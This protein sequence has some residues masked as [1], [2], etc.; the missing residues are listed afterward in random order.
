MLA[1]MLGGP[2]A[3]VGVQGASA[4]SAGGFPARTFYVAPWGSDLNPGTNPDHPWRSVYH[5]N[6]ARLKPGDRVLFRGGVTFNDAA[7]MPGAAGTWVTGTAGAPVTFASYGGGIAR[8]TKGIYF[9]ASSRLPDGPSYLTFKNL[10]LGAA[11]GFEGT[12]DWITLTGLRI[13]NLYAPG[14]E[15][16]ILTQ[17]SHWRITGNTINGTGD[18][19]MLLGFRSGAPGAPS[20]GDDY[21]VAHNVV[22]RTGL[23]HKLTFGTHGIYVKVSDATVVQNRITRFHD[24]GVSVRYRNANVAGNDISRGGIGVAWFQYDTIPGTSRFV[25]NTISHTSSA[26]VFVCGTRE[27]CMRPIESFVI[28]GNKILDAQG[29]TLNLQ[30]TRGTYRVSRNFRRR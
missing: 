20:G 10:A 9:G 17:G 29:D 4:D 5:V 21:Y 6:Q 24:D 26:A 19:G 30:P 11:A 18:S 15:V 2:A 27:G 13:G 22:T 8:L 7:L 23:N 25:D 14:P 12:G 16:G 1:V 28:S 3:T